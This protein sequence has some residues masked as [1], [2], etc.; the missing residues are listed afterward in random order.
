MSQ[1]LLSPP[2]ITN[3]TPI[4]TWNN[5]RPQ[6]E[7]EDQKLMRR[8]E[9]PVEN[10]PAVAPEL[11]AE[12]KGKAPV[13]TKDLQATADR[14]VAEGQKAVALK[15]WEEGVNKYGD[16]LEAMYVCYH[17]LLVTSCG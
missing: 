8:S 5:V 17:F 15:Q 11:S 7:W 12:D 14:L 2:L 6:P 3:G 9:A 4:S 16:A 10:T 13:D 1:K